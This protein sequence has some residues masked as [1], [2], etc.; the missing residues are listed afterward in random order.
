MST[1]DDCK[2]LLFLSFKL[3]FMDELVVVDV[4]IR[5]SHAYMKDF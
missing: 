3:M 5:L 4:E 1:I 2:K